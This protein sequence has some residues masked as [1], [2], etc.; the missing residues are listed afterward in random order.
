MAIIPIVKCQN[1]ED[2]VTFYTKVLDFVLVG[3]W[4]EKSNPSFSILMREGGELHLSFHQ[5]DG[6][7]GN[8][9]AIIVTDVDNLFKKYLAYGLNTKTKL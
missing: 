3:T 6:T 2:S 7:F 9:V 1:M 4:P 8:A 5:G